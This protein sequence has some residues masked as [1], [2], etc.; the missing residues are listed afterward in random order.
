[1]KREVS[2]LLVYDR[3]GPLD[4]LSRALESHWIVPQHSKT[5]REA[6]RVISAGHAPHLIFTDTELPDGT[7]ADV[8]ALA[9]NAPTPI[10][11]I[12]V[13][14]RIDAKPYIEAIESGAFDF[15]APP[16]GATEL[17]Y[18]VRCAA[19]N[20]LNRRDAHAR[21]QQCRSRAPVSSPFLS[22]LQ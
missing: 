11:V 7:W 21:A 14:H 1:M 12:V 3:T 2:A 15:I 18:V 10:N 9:A 6:S 5:C 17:A 16:F 19:E 13:A 20:V 22:V 4:T 8:L